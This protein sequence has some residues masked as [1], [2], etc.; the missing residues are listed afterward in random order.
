MTQAFTLPY[1]LPHGGCCKLRSRSRAQSF[2]IEST[3][4]LTFWWRMV[5]SE[6]Q[7]PLFQIML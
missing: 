6:N 5:F 3:G 7:F 1:S 4:A 2:Q